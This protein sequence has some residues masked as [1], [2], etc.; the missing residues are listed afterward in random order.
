MVFKRAIY[1]VAARRT[2]FGTYGGKLKDFSAT[3]LQELA[4]RA[5]LKQANLAPEAIDSTIVGNVMQSSSDAAYIARHA[6][7][8]AGLPITVPALTVNRLCGSGFQAIISGGQEIEMS[9]SHVVLCGGA[10]SMSQAPYAVRNARF[11]TKLGQDLKLE[12]TLWQGL[13]DEYAKTPMGVTGELHLSLCDPSQLWCLAENLAKKYSLTRQDTDQYALQSQ[14]RWKKA[15]DQGFFKDEIEPIK[16]KGKKGAEDVFDTDE[17]PRPQSTLETLSK[18]PA[19]FKKENGTVTAGNASGVC[20]GAGAVLI[21]TEEALKKYNLTP[22]ARLIGYHVSGVEPTLMG[23]GPVPAIENLL[24]KTKKQVSDIDLFDINEAFAPQ[25][26]S[27][28]KAL[29]LPNEKTNVNGGA[30]ALGHPLGA[31]GTRITANLVYELKRR[32]GKYAVGAACIGGGQG[33]S[34]MIERVWMWNFF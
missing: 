23:F 10:E 20:D 8:R 11:G 27:C 2:P 21:C 16:T 6:A 13:T 18:L 25:F 31:S 29:K 1:I 5:V 14:Q 15:H 24:K 9:D 32:Q 30:I 28:Q 3:H 19:V 12:D 17:H 4:N 34:L 33:I 7:L 22:L 26:L